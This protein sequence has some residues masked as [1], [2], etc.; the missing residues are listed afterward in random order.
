MNFYKTLRNVTFFDGFLCPKIE[1]SWG[2]TE[3]KARKKPCTWSTWV[4]WIIFKDMHINYHQLSLWFFFGMDG[5]GETFWMHHGRMV[6]LK[7]FATFDPLTSH[8]RITWNIFAACRWWPLRA[9]LASM[10]T[11]IWPRRQAIE[12]AMVIR[13]EVASGQK[14]QRYE[15]II[16]FKSENRSKEFFLLAFCAP[17]IP[18]LL[19]RRWISPRWC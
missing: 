10:K 4:D 3:F 18:M 17:S 1:S 2:N 11:R 14:I 5:F 6:K 13:A 7:I 8:G 12:F 15:L 19:A 16:S 9:S